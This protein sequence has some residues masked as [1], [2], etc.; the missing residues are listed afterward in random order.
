MQSVGTYD[1]PHYEKTHIYTLWDPDLMHCIFRVNKMA[2]ATI[3][4]VDTGESTDI[5]CVYFN[6][7]SSGIHV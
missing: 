3:T 7:G 4:N 1:A 2:D 6:L 5:S